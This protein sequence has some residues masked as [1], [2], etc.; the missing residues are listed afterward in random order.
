MPIAQHTRRAKRRAGSALAAAPLTI[1]LAA[2]S[3]AITLAIAVGT[4]A[5]GHVPQSGPLGLIC[6]VVLAAAAAAEASRP[7]RSDRVRRRLPQSPHT[8]AEVYAPSQV[9]ARGR[10]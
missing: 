1:V 8:G 10:L 4:V 5:D 6:A 7:A 2:L 3:I 9:I